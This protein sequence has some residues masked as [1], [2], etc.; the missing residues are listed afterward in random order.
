MN[1]GHFPVFPLAQEVK[2]SPNKFILRHY[3]IRSYEQGLKKV[4]EDRLPRYAPSESKRGWHRHY[5]NFT[6]EKQSFVIDSKKL[7][8][9]N[10]DG[11]WN[12]ERTLDPWL[13][14]RLLPEVVVLRRK[15]EEKQAQ[16]KRLQDE[17]D[18]KNAR[19]TALERELEQLMNRFKQ[20]DRQNEL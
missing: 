20:L 12:M 6:R 11:K 18:M 3:R 14:D 7:T 8:K 1:T 17:L 15:I 5:S 2:I 10:E 13:G 9:Y 4:F 19:I 16:T